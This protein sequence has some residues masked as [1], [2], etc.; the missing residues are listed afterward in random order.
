MKF[1]IKNIGCRMNQFD[2]DLIYTKMIQ[3]G[4][5]FSESFADIYIVNTCSVTKDA[6]RSS[7]QA[8]YQFKRENPNAI[9]VATGCYAQIKP[10]E[11]LNLEEVDL[12]VGNTHK[13]E[14]VDII[15]N[16]L[17]QREKKALVGEIF[18]VKEFK[19]FSPYIFFER[20]RPFIKVQEG[21]NKF[22]SFCVIPFARGKVRSAKLDD[23]IDLL[24]SVSERGFEEIVLTGTQLSQYGEDINSSL[25]ELLEKALTVEGLKLIRL[26]SLHIKEIDNDL[27]S[28]LVS[29]DRIAPHFHLSLQSGSDKIL[30]SMERDYLVYEY[31]DIFDFI[32]QK[33]P[34]SA[35]GTD[36]I[37]GFP[38]ETEK[39]FLESYEFLSK[40]DFAYLHVFTYSDRE[41]TKAFSMQEKVSSSV[42]KERANLLLEL[43]KKKRENFSKKM[44]KLKLRAT[45]IN[46]NEL[47]TENY[48]KMNYNTHNSQI[49]KVVEVVYEHRNNS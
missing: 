6:E 35:I 43:D 2:T 48:L 7:R 36:I 40:K 45:V 32:T 46:K 4:F 24:K 23:V 41:F 31:E 3:K 22:C 11:L 1:N 20:A 19:N 12:V 17:E 47:L 25:K 42:K 33:R 18:R 21:C 14:I 39:D 29:E 38:T 28:M 9:L 8:I 26:S 16:F 49:G 34:I 5:Y 15:E 27:L 10:E 13:D 30:D 37:V 44:D